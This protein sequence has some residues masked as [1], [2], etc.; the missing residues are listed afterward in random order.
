M[1]SVPVSM[2][3]GSL[4][5]LGFTLA[6]ILGA[7]PLNGDVKTVQAQTQPPNSPLTVR[8][9]IQEAN[10]ET[11]VVTARGNVQI[12]YPSRQL[13]GTAV[14]AQYFSRERRLV[15]TGNVYVLQQGNSMRAESM[16]YLIDEGRFIATP[17]TKQQVESI[18]LVTEAEETPPEPASVTSPPPLIPS[19]G[20]IPLR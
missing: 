17:D 6:L 5:A 16:T 3:K 7:V 1:F 13:Q 11:G 15:L 9:D 12:F 18:Y 4:T 14:Q 19:D 10:S 2:V 20:L 8:S